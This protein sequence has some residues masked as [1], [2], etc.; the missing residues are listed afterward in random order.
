MSKSSIL[1]VIISFFAIAAFGQL[2]FPSQ[3]ELYL[4]FTAVGGVATTVSVSIINEYARF[5]QFD[6]AVIT[7]LGSSAAADVVIT[8]SLVYSLV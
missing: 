6:G 7:W 2:Y 3:K 5:H 4:T 1:P 8:A